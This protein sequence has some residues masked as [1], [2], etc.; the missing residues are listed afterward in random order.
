M[1]IYFYKNYLIYYF[2]EYNNIYLQCKA[3]KLINNEFEVNV[4]IF[5]KNENV[6][7]LLQRFRNDVHNEN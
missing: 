7:L 2:Y 3:L 1:R 4:G 6:Q 5:T